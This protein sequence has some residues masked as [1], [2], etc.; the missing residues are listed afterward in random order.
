MAASS[1]SAVFSAL[2]GNGFLTVLKFAVWSVSG[3]GAMFSEAIHTLADTANQGLL[4]LGIRRSEKGTDAMFP[5]GRGA[6]RYLYALLSA[7]GIFVL[8]CGV[9]VYHGGYRRGGDW[10]WMHDTVV[11]GWDHVLGDLQGW[12]ARGDSR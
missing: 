10:D 3:S 6:E 1:T 12:F 4:F 7:V 2:I 9:T 11:A 8:G 5:Y